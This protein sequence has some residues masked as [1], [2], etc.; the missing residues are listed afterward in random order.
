MTT[1]NEIYHNGLDFFGKEQY[2]EA[3]VEYRKALE[4]DPNDGELYLAL[5]IAYLRMDDLETA[6]I[7]ARL[8]TEKAPDEPLVY[9]NL[10]RIMQKSGMI[11]EAEEAMGIA[12]HL[13]MR[14]G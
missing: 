6:L 4:I 12:R 5:S 8:S 10:S 7:N 9:T 2:E 1:K 14:M 13:S 11:H 3:I